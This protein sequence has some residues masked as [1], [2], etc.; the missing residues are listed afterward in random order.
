MEHF[1]RW[2][3]LRRRRSYI[4]VIL[5]QTGLRL[6]PKPLPLDHTNL[7]GMSEVWLIF[8]TCAVNRTSNFS[9]PQAA[10][11]QLKPGFNLVYP[12]VAPPTPPRP[13]P[14]LYGHERIL[15]LLFL[16]FLFLL[17]AWPLNSNAFFIHAMLNRPDDG[18]SAV[19]KHMWHLIGRPDPGPLA[20]YILHKWKQWQTCWTLNARVTFHYWQL[21]FSALHGFM[22]FVWKVTE[23]KK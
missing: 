22:R 4:L 8:M 5:G 13:V 10:E 7:N 20:V 3:G 16:F 12:G 9:K 11:Q 1:T 17:K 2:T 15:L 6:K 23:Q 18:L 19:I 21:S 14:P